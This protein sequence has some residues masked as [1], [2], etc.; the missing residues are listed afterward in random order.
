MHVRGRF[1]H[2][3]APFMTLGLL[4]TGLGALPEA[5]AS[6][7]GTA[8]S[9]SPTGHSSTHT[10]TF[11]WAPVKGA[12][13]YEIQVDD[14][15]TFDS[16]LVTVSTTNHRF[17]PTTNLPD[18]TLHWRVR[19]FSAAGKHGSWH[20]VTFSV[21]DIAAPRPT[22]PADG[23]KLSQP[24]QP[25]L[26][27]WTPVAGATGYDVE[28]DADGDWIDTTSYMSAGPSFQIPQPQPA[29][30][31][32]WRVRAELGGGLVSLWSEGS[33]YEIMP[34]ADVQMD[35]SMTDGG[36]MEDVALKW[37]PV[38]GAAQYELQVAL[39]RDFT[40]P[41]E[42]RVVKSTRYS[43][44]TTY[45]NDQYFWRVR[46][47]D[48]AGTKMEWPA[49]PFLFQRDW[50]EQP[51]LVYPGDAV[52]PPVGDDFYFQWTPVIHATRYQLDVGTD[53]NFSP[54]T[55]ATCFTATTT[56]TPTLSD[57][58]PGQGVVTYWRVKPVDSPRS[59][60]VQ[61]IFSEIH[62][63][64]Y[65]SSAVRALSP[66]D[67]AAV[68][69]PTL[70]WEPATD[71]EQYYV[72]VR[73]KADAVVASTTT[74]STS[75]TPEGANG[76]DP[77][78]G[79][80]SWTVQAV[81]DGG[82][83]SPK[84]Q[85]WTFTLAGTPATSGAGALTPLLSPDGESS[86]RFP[87][88]TWE[89]MAGAKYY[90]IQ[91]GIGGSG[92]WD[93][94]NASHINAASF[95]YPAAT[96]TGDRYLNPGT[97]DWR[98]Q[99][100]SSSN[101]S[102]GY[103]SVGHFVIADLD[104]TAGQQI[105]LDGEALD[106]GNSCRNALADVV[107][108]ADICTG[109]PATPVL[110]W[111]PVPGAGLYMVYV[112]ND[113][114]LTNIIYNGVVTKNSR[115]TPASGM[116]KEALA[117]NQAGQSYYWYVRPC[118]TTSR[119][120]PDPVSTHA[121]A[122][123]AFR[124]ISPSPVLRSPGADSVNHCAD[125][126]TLD[127]AS[128]AD[129][130][131]FSWDDYYDTNQTKYY[132]GGSAPSPQTA[133][134]Y[135]IE[136]ANS[137]TFNSPNLVDAKEVD[138][139]TYTPFDR[140]LPEGDLWWRVQAI[141]AEG[142]HLAWSDIAKITKDSGKV[143]LNYPIDG[144]SA[145]GTTPFSWKPKSGSASYRIEVYKNDDATFSPS[146]RI[147]YA[148]TPLSSYVWSRYLPASPKAYRWRVRWHDSGGHD[149]AWSTTGRFFVKSRPVALTA[150]ASGAKVAPRDVLFTWQAVTSASRYLLV[151]RNQASGSTALQMGTVARAFAPTGALAKG[152]YQWRVVAYDPN[153][154][155]LGQTAWRKV[156]VSG[157]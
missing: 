153:G 114:E 149:G 80:F 54:R 42:T 77:T 8:G 89:P 100:F 26:L 87:D 1:T 84:H 17:V 141:D 94:T 125:T 136:I 96:D 60:G 106:S 150:P 132:S 4:L 41:V 154:G 131:A 3:L 101:A 30:V 5:S 44:T 95:P 46:A 83:K 113:R 2:R 48:S 138:Q 31:W 105:A 10:P 143:Q 39:D 37:L 61:G 140:T 146:N 69:V 157:G 55:F 29:Q 75:W 11:S 28:V 82:S 91:I 6:A 127:G 85:G 59:P 27:A 40:Q 20:S 68:A 86:V 19:A 148:D 119:C 124:K 38:P 76:L 92:F 79:P 102:L 7:V 74:A 25:A 126:T 129:D 115:W 23:S 45:D 97:Y 53:P 88:L 63:F 49:S 21:D 152:T 32:S 13:S 70:R 142:N 156:S 112:A 52:S 58:M 151:V 34:L 118:K 122:T 43:P 120:A 121:A 16:N 137:S 103:G 135:R 110:D 116:A 33:T 72:E 90:K 66:A 81:D 123:N 155:V 12:S 111:S 73:S 36:T 109:V 144:A 134:K 56:Y 145:P 67:G 62:R 51:Q 78:K 47:I 139:A 9:M 71:A 128:C 107:S 64:V 22:S 130:I 147:L 117:D 133:Q 15:P 24:S 99:A 108:E 57:C 50:P 65:E 98:V 35:P 104:V 14:S 93:P 18:G